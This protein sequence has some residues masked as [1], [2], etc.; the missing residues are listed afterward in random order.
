MGAKFLSSSIG[1]VFLLA[2]AA[3]SLPWV[4]WDG[5]TEAA[6]GRGEKGPWQ[7]NDSRYDYV[8]DPTVAIDGAGTITLAWVDQ[9]N[10]DV[11][12]QKFSK[13]G[14]R[15]GATINASRNPATF[16]W[17]PRIVF[18]SDDPKEIYLLWQEIIFSGGSHGGDILFARSDV[19]WRRWRV[20]R[21][22][23]NLGACNGRRRL[24]GVG[25]RCARQAVR[26]VGGIS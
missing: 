22:A 5:V 15:Q 10:K 17:L 21:A 9:K 13:E 6:V 11:F 23:D 8:D 19:E 25:D 20:C 16:S 2:A 4:R 7:Q 3:N 18:P 12:F 24:S 1:A 26:D 14:V